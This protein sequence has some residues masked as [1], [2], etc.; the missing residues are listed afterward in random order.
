MNEEASVNAALFYSGKE[1]SSDQTNSSPC[2]SG[3]LQKTFSFY[4]QERQQIVVFKFHFKCFQ[5]FFHVRARKWRSEWEYILCWSTLNYKLLDPFEFAFW[6]PGAL[7]CVLKS[8]PD[9]E[10]EAH[11]APLHTRSLWIP[12]GEVIVAEVDGV[13]GVLESYKNTI[14]TRSTEVWWHLAG[15]SSGGTHDPMTHVWHQTAGDSEEQRPSSWRLEHASCT[16]VCTCAH[17]HP[18]RYLFTTDGLLCFNGESRQYLYYLCIDKECS[19]C[20]G[21][22]HTSVNPQNFY[23]KRNMPIWTHSC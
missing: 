4:T 5:I 23:V 12:G 16:L 20:Y 2:L 21:N 11:L 7:F 3:W 9:S 8:N 15:P 13:S 14:K 1:S 10:S 6:I 19:G 22:K 17:Q 18:L